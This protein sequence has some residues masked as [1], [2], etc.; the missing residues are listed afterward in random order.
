MNG[1]ESVDGC[2][3]IENNMQKPESPPS[4][5][6]PKTINFSLNSFLT[7][8]VHC[9]SVF[10][11]MAPSFANLKLRL[12]LACALMAVVSLAHAQAVMRRGQSIIFSS[13]DDDAVVSNVPSLSPKPPVLSGFAGAVQAPEINFNGSPQAAPLPAPSAPVVSTAETSQL[14]RLL[15]ERK[16]WTMLTP[17]EILGLPTP[18]KML[19]IPDRDSTS[20][21]DNETV[22]ERFYERQENLSNANTNG[23]VTDKSAQPWNFSND[24][25]LQSNPIF[26]IPSN[27]HPANSAFIDQFLKGPPANNANAGQN[28][29]LNWPKLFGSPAPS[30]TPD[31]QA[32]ADEIQKLFEPQPATP[33][34]AGTSPGDTFFSGSQKSSGT[35]LGQPMVNPIGASY[36]PLSSGIG[37]PVGVTPLPGLFTTK[38]IAPAPPEWKP[39]PPPWMSSAPQL[40]VIPQRKF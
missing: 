3:L 38:P 15:D 12:F 16:N 14:E 7:C 31:Q 6:N 11:E 25:P 20:P 35:I 2:W 17:E 34:T 28:P 32:E 37:L 26:S 18:E 24:Q 1:N 4:T 36:T 5:I 29:D 13:P 27:N 39:Q 8:G 33:S 30:Q 9:I 23:L 22:A 19:G 40:G 21:L 10:V